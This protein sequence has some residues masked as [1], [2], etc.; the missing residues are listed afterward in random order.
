M[1]LTVTDKQIDKARKRELGKE[2]FVNIIRT[3][4]PF[5]FQ[6]VES[7]AGRLNSGEHIAIEAPLHMADGDRNQLLRVFAST[8]MRHALEDHFGLAELAFQN[9]HYIGGADVEGL[10]DERWQIFTSIEGQV[11]AQRPELRDC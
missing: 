5:A 8:S 3:S 2:E 9:C 6:A 4:L 10:D 7:L 11:L 1:S